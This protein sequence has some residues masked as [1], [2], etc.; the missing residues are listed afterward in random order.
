MNPLSQSSKVRQR[1]AQL[2]QQRESAERVLLGRQKLLKG[3]VSEVRRMCGKPGCK[4]TKGEKH[5]CYQ[6]SA[7]V[8]SRTHTQNVP[9]KQLATV[10]R[11]TEHYRRFRQARA[12][13]VR[14]NAQITELINQLES[15]RTIRN[16]PD[17]QRRKK[18]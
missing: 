9:R 15:V 3:T 16:I 13:W 10:R 8:E 5:V 18:G 1:I 17:E 6:L 2:V 11:L 14:F 4:C 12:A 7:S